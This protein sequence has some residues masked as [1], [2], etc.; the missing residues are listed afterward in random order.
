MQNKHRRVGGSR[1]DLVQGRHA[2][3]GELKFRPATHHPHPLRRRGAHRLVFEHV[4]RVGNRGHAFPAQLHIIV[5][6]AANEVG[7][8][9]VEPRDHPAATKID[10]IGLGIRQRHD[11]RRIAHRLDQPT[12]NGNRLSLRV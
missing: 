3:L 6:P 7:V 2:A 1:V 4:Q 10:N 12:T 9:V 8:A 11:L 5:Q